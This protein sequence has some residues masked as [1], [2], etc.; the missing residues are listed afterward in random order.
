MLIR[1]TLT[2]TDDQKIV[3]VSEN[4]TSDYPQIEEAFRNELAALEGLPDDPMIEVTETYHVPGDY[5]YKDKGILENIID[6]SRDLTRSESCFT[7]VSVCR[8]GDA[9][10]PLL[11]MDLTS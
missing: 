4:T 10:C 1:H 6:Q 8:D 3:I 5:M 7:C 2:F 9:C 11:P